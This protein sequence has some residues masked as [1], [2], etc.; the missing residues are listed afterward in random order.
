MAK[1]LILYASDA[2]PIIGAL[3][4]AL[5]GNSVIL[6]NIEQ[7]SSV[8]AGSALLAALRDADVG[9]LLASSSLL[10]K[11]GNLL[12]ARRFGDGPRRRN[13]EGMRIFQL[14]LQQPKQ[15]ERQLW[16]RWFAAEY[17][18]VFAGNP[19]LELPQTQLN[20]QLAEFASYLSR[21]ANE[22]SPPALSTEFSTEFRTSLPTILNLV[23][24]DQRVVELLFA[25]NRV[26]IGD[27]MIVDFNGERSDRLTFGVTRIRVPEDHKIGKLEIP[28]TRNWLRLRFS[29]EPSSE[30]NHFVIKEISIVNQDRFAEAL[31]DHPTHS[32]LVFAHGF[33]T[34]FN[35]GVLRLAQIVWDMQF[36]GLPIL[37]SW[38]SRGGLLN[39]LYDLN[40]A[41]D[42]RRWFSALILLCKEAKVTTLHILA[43]SMGNLV[44]LEA[45]SNLAQTATIPPLSE[46]V[47][48][49]PDV[50]VDIFK[51]LASA[52]QPSARGMTLYASDSDKALITA[53]R[54]AKKPRAGDS[55]ADGPI[56]LAD[57]ESID[58]SAIGGEMFG[59]N[60][61]V[62]ASNRSLIDDIGRLLATG[63]RPPDL[64]SPQIRGAPEGI[65]PPK[66][67]RYAR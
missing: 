34:S 55:F 54:M 18:P 22:L 35:E 31:A 2:E 63:S 39:Y 61:N 53:R 37:F 1:I 19:I 45:L 3:Q 20:R 12:R 4:L 60:H 32:A 56:T 14:N 36:K 8:G 64:R 16:R 51:T 47:M 24:P 7:F 67:W 58:V 33:N 46:I 6:F 38:P 40:S 66:Y 27:R 15:R 59:L 57:M 44:A 13:R 48:A 5:R 23:R 21:L 9:L 28:Q 65:E 11:T 50:D 30:R 41:M 25:T 17:D 43:H 42:A 10:S 62:F 26:P 49:A 52:L 29:D